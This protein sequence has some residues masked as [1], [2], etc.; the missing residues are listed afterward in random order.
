MALIAVFIGANIIDSGLITF[1]EKSRISRVFSKATIAL[2]ITFVVCTLA[3]LVN[4][5]GIKM[6]IY[7][8]QT[9]NDPAI[10]Q[11]IQEW[12]SPNFHEQVWL[13]LVIMILLLIAAGMRSAR[14]ISTVNILLC[15][16]SLYAVLHATK[17]ISLFA[18]VTIPVLSMLVSSIVTLRNNPAPVTKLFRR[19]FMIIMIGCVFAVILAITQLNKKQAEIEKSLF[20]TDAVEWVMKNKPQGN[21]FN[22]YNWG[23]YLIWRLYPEYSVFIDGRCDMYGAEFLSNYIDIRETKPG[24]EEALT[25]EKIGWVLVEKNSNLANNLRQSSSWENAYEDDMSVIFLKHP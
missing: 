7:P 2:I 21:V 20:P 15:V 9:V 4:P 18:L 22:A 19:G 8:F 5:N 12:A 24:W 11:F 16:I 14:P 23:G 1:R 13:P 10:G 3:A 6:L 25:K 17:Q